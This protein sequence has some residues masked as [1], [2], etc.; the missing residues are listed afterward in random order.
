MPGGGGL[1]ATLLSVSERRGHALHAL[2]LW[3]GCLLALRQRQNLSNALVAS[4]L[5]AAAMGGVD[6]GPRGRRSAH[7]DGNKLVHLEGI[8]MAN[9]QRVVDVPALAERPA[10]PAWS[11]LRA[12]PP[13]NV[14]PPLIVCVPGVTAHGSPYRGTRGGICT[15]PPVYT[16]RPQRSKRRGL[17]TVI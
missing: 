15:G 8:R 9:W 6:V 5:V 16:K 13:A 2:S 14:D 4:P 17:C 1:G 12:K 11:A 10:Y 3:S 7:G